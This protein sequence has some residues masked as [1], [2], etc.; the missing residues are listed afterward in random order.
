MTWST[1][2]EALVP[3]DPATSRT[4]PPRA[5]SN[6]A[7]AQ[8]RNPPRKLAC[9]FARTL[10]A[11]PGRDSDIPSPVYEDDKQRILG[12]LG[13]HVRHLR[14]DG[15]QIRLACAGP[16][17]TDP[18]ARRRGLGALLARRLLAGPQEISSSDG[19]NDI[20]RRLAAAAG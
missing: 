18:E 13:V 8:S 11:Y 1:A 10:L 6:R 5:F 7:S 17:A 16:M 3:F 9:Y 15:R 20:S 4:P 12:F 2:M 19:A 14:F